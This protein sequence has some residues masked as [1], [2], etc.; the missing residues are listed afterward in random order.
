MSRRR[1]QGSSRGGP[2][3]HSC[4]TPDTGTGS[5]VQLHTTSHH[6]LQA[7]SWGGTVPT[8]DAPSSL[9]WGNNLD[10]GDGSEVD[11][12]P[13]VAAIASSDWDGRNDWDLGGRH[14]GFYFFYLYLHCIDDRT[15]ASTIR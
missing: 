9:T 14:V 5:H 6:S 3:R 13:S 1:N 11:G 8:W 15:I 2:S 4:A 10:W 7:E 12:W